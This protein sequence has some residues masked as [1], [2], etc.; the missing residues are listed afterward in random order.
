MLPPT[1]KPNPCH[2]KGFLPDT[3]LL[4]SSPSHIPVGPLKSF[5]NRLDFGN[6]IFIVDAYCL[7]RDFR[8]EIALNF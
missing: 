1:T 6:P 4:L 3:L 7:N 2:Y 5:T 8:L